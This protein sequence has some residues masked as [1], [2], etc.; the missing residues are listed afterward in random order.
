MALTRSVVPFASLFRPCT[1][2]NEEQNVVG[3]LGLRWRAEL[4]TL[5]FS[6]SRN[7]A[8]RSDGTEVVQDQLRFYIDR[9]VTRRLN[10]SFAVVALQESAVGQVFQPT[11]NTF[12]LARQDR[13]YASFDFNVYWRMTQTMTAYV[14]YTHR[15]D[16]T[17]VTS[18]NV[19]KDN[20]RLFLG[21]KY[22]GVGLRR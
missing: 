20:D 2:H 6:L 5:N 8:P 7:I 12:Q 17:D 11:S 1:I 22:R 19:D 18:G 13:T 21:V 3:S 4:T 10:G 16:R 14:A 9:T 15:L